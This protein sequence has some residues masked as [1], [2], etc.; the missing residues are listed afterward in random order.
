MADG[1]AGCA[2]AACGGV[3]AAGSGCTAAGAAGGRGC[4]VTAGAGAGATSSAGATV[5][6]VSGGVLPNFEITKATSPAATSRPTT[7]ATMATRP[8]PRLTGLDAGVTTCGPSGV[9]FSDICGPVLTDGVEAPPMTTVRS[10][11]S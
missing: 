9:S 7:L 1:A 10:L 4:G 11:R 8:M 2:S 3:V 5:A 6:T